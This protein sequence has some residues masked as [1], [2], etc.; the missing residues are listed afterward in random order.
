MPARLLTCQEGREKRDNQKQEKGS[1]DPEPVYTEEVEGQMVTAKKRNE[2]ECK[3][4]C[5]AA[6]DNGPPAG[7]PGQQLSKKALS[8]SRL[9][10]RGAT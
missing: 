7:F 9:T 1:L 8:S 5:Y 10:L 3:E 6:Q 2:Q 4:S